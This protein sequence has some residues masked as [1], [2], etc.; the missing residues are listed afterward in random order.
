MSWRGSHEFLLSDVGLVFVAGANGSGK[1][2]IMDAICWCLFGRASKLLLADDV[3]NNKEKKNCKVAISATYKDKKIL[4]RRYRKHAKKGNSVE[5]WINKEKVPQ[6][7]DISELIKKIVGCSYDQFIRTCF[8]SQA[9]RRYFTQLTESVQREVIAE[10]YDFGVIRKGRKKARM[11]VMEAAAEAQELNTEYVSSQRIVEDSI[12]RIEKLEKKIK[13]SS[14]KADIDKK[15]LIL[16]KQKIESDIASINE[17]LLEIEEQEDSL[18]TREELVISY[19]KELNNLVKEIT[20]VSSS[21][22][23]CSK[24][25]QE[26]P[27]KSS[28]VKRLRKQKQEIS[29]HLESARAS[30]IKQKKS[31]VPSSPL[32]SELHDLKKTLASINTELCRAQISL[33]ELSSTLKNEE[34]TLKNRELKRDKAKS[35]LK[36]SQD[37]LSYLEFWETG[38]GSK[39]LENMAL[40][41]ALPYF[42]ARVNHYLRQLP[43]CKGHISVDYRLE[44]DRLKSIISYAGSS[45]YGGASGG[46]KRRIDIAVSLALSDLSGFDNNVLMLDEPFEGI[47]SS[48]YQDVVGLLAS[49]DGKSVLVCSHSPQLRQYFPSTWH[50]KIDSQGS[51]LERI[52]HQSKVVL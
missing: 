42:N 19:E 23:V 38:L 46:E 31:I 7:V 39:G 5:L 43:T 48:A 30:Y 26:L 50:I 32:I 29:R 52:E 25:G 47:E 4:I 10:L 27:D 14:N 13:V 21:D 3:V 44:K 12:N 49:L 8:F 1:S 2:S 35:A 45:K 41:Q 18:V 33:E 22:P 11:L 36:K 40:E 17:A 37:H 24:C 34:K 20:K 9:D 51:K 16:K 6:K 15:S 28:I